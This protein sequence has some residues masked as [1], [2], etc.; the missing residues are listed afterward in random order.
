MPENPIGA[1]EGTIFQSQHDALNDELRGQLSLYT[2]G[3]LDAG[4]AHSCE[5]HLLQCELCAQEVR[6]DMELITAV[7]V[8]EGERMAAA[9]QAPDM[10]AALMKRIATEPSTGAS[11]LILRAA[12]GVWKKVLPGIEVKRLFFDPV[13]ESVT[14]LVRVAAGAVYPAHIHRGLEHLYVL[15]GDIVFDDHTLSSGDYEVRTPDTRHSS[16]TTAPGE[17]CLLLVINCERDEFIL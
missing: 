11:P 6:A 5:D 13:T 14:S 3:L 12:E 16:A 9:A 7:A 10:R 2:L 4:T 15:D 17:P 1:G 8:T